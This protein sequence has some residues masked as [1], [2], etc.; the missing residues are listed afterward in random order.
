MSAEKMTKIKYGKLLEV[1]YNHIVANNIE[2]SK[3]TNK[4]FDELYENVKKE[5]GG[6]LSKNSFTS[7]IELLQYKQDNNILDEFVKVE[8]YKN[9]T[10]I[11]ANFI[12]LQA[13]S[14]KEVMGKETFIMKRIDDNTINVTIGSESKVNSCKKAVALINSYNTTNQNKDKLE[15]SFNIMDNVYDSKIG[16]LVEFQKK[17]IAMLDNMRR[18]DEFAKKSAAEPS[19]VGLREKYLLSVMLR[20]EP[21]NYQS[22][23]DGQTAQKNK[24]MQTMDTSNKIVKEQI[25]LTDVNIESMAVLLKKMVKSN[26]CKYDKDKS[27]FSLSE[28]IDKN[29]V[30]IFM[31]ESPSDKPLDVDLL[32]RSAVMEQQESTEQHTQVRKNR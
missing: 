4:T 26:I 20:D 16:D 12:L 28:N 30:A 6:S 25:Q 13:Q 15:K 14:K 19:A 22:F 24:L 1:V 27:T 17:I 9:L 5:L 7:V 23:C 2:T 29:D 10:K 31:R 11:K 3:L 18:A 8:D 21:F 32:A